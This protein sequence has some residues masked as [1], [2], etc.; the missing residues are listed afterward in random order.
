MFYF[1]FIHS[2][3]RPEETLCV[4]AESNDLMNHL[5]CSWKNFANELDFLKRLLWIDSFN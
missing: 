1:S 4:F 3:H 5:F 2:M